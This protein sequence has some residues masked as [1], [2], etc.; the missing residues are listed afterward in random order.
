[1]PSAPPAFAGN[2][3]VTG[4]PP[5]DPEDNQY[6]V[7]RLPEPKSAR[8]ASISAI[9]VE[10]LNTENSVVCVGKLCERRDRALKTVPINAEIDPFES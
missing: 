6:A 9:L 8:A 7:E 2:V 4:P 10:V 5:I 3:E 1:M